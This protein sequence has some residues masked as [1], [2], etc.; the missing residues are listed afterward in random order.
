[1]EDILRRDCRKAGQRAGDD[2][3]QK[4]I[5]DAPSSAVHLRCKKQSMQGAVKDS[6]TAQVELPGGS[7]FMQILLETHIAA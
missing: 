6:L 7:N 4:A 2:V 1:M 5:Q 3:R